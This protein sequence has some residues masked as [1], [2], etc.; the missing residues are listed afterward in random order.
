L[1]NKISASLDRGESCLEVF[2]DLKKAFDTVDSG[3]LLGKL[4]RNGVRGNTLN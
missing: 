4:E 2:L 1:T 3:I